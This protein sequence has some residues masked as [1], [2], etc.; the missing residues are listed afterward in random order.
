GTVDISSADR[1]AVAALLIGEPIPLE[2]LVIADDLDR[3]SSCLQEVRRRALS[4]QEERG[5]MTLFVALGMATWKSA[6]E[7]RPAESPVLLLP[8]RIESKGR[9]A[10]RLVLTR[11]GDVQ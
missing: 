7:G 5:L 9:D 8:L 3:A 11:D 10:R 4:N 6:D 1:A 2:K